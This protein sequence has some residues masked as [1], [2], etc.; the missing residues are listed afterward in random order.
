[1]HREQAFFAQDMLHL[2]ATT[3]S[4]GVRFDHYRLIEEEHA[5]SPR[6][7]IA[8]YE[9]R[10]GLSLRASYDRAFQTPSIENVILS[11]SDL[12]AQLGG[13]GRSLPLRSSRGHFSEAGVSKTFSSHLRVDAT[14]FY[15]TATNVADDDLLLNTAVS[16]P[17]A[18]SSGTVQGYDVKVDVPRWGS[19][20]GSI[21]YSHSVGTAE[22]PAA[23]GLFLGDEVAS[24]LNG[25]GRFPISQDQRHTVRGRLQYRAGARGWI[26][27]STQFNSGL[28]TEL[29]DE[30]NLPL[31]VAQ[32]GQA[33]VDRVDFVRG[34]VGASWS[35]DASIGWSLFERDGRS[36]RLQ[37][38]VFN[39][40]DRLNVINFAG[41]LSGTA[42]APR[43]T[44]AV[45]AHV[46][47]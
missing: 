35:A 44:W 3:V 11:S 46:G 45:R 9:P 37:A 16:F 40:F 41:L 1:L 34:R 18:Y 25:T 30:P 38:D 4:L 22:L 20:S 8:W 28:P 33:I 27:G 7:A 19:T 10:A 43:R 6:L 31:L 24:L 21:V 26:A 36:L 17:I 5:V 12:V 15:R 42:V 47:F 32:Y 2:G 14:Y 13:E 29:D 39:V 23:G